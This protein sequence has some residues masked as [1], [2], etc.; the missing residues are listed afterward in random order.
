M[1]NPFI[2]TGATDNPGNVFPGASV[3]FGMAKFGIDVDEYAPAGTYVFDRGDPNISFKGYNDDP[4]GL[5]RGLSLL[6]DTGTGSSSGSYGN[7]ESQ[8]VVC[9]NDNYNLCPVSLDAR[10][11]LRAAGKDAASPGYFTTTLDN[12]IKVGLSSLLEGFK[13]SFCRWKQL[14]VVGLACFVTLGLLHC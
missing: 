10:K 4:A 3:P 8:P 13:S 9:S 5:I 12:D 1:V 2:G 6:H 11:R 7:F 14:Q